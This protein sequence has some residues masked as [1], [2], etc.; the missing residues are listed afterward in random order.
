[1]NK[2]KIRNYP[3]PYKRIRV[4]PDR[5]LRA[6]I[7]ELAMID[8]RI[9]QRLRN[10]K[11]LGNSNVSYPTAEHS[12]FAHSLGVL[13]WATKILNSL[14]DNHNAKHNRQKL[15]ELNNSV[16]NYMKKKLTDVNVAIFGENVFL[17][18]TWFEQL[19]RVYA[20]LHDLSHIPFGHT[21]EDQAALFK[22]HDDDL[23]RLNLVFD[24]LIKEVR[25]SYH[26]KNVD[27]AEELSE[28]AIEYI[29]MVKDIFVVGNITSDP[30]SYDDTRNRWFD[31][32]DEQIYKPLLLSYD[33]VSNT[34][35]ADLMDY[36]LR[37]TLFSSIPKTFDKSL[38]ICMKI[39]EHETTFY[40][41]DKLS[42]KMYR[43]GINISRKKVR[44]DMITAILDLL[45]IRYDLTEKVYY[46]H[47]KI[48]ADS[49]LEKVLRLIKG[50]KNLQFTPK[51]IYEQ[52][53]GDEG[54]ISLLE[55]KIESNGGLSSAK[56]I[57]DEILR[58]NLYKAAFR[59]TRNMPLSKEGRTNVKKCKSPEGRDELE[60][61]IVRELVEDCD[62]DIKAGDIIISYP[63]EKMQEKDAK[64][65]IEWSDGQIFTF[66]RLPL[67]ANYSNEVGVLTE[68]YKTLWSMTVYI[69]PNK[70]QYLRLVEA[71]C[72]TKFDI[73]N[74]SI[75]KNYLTEKYKEIYKSKGD[76]TDIKNKAISIES[77]FI[78]SKAAKGGSQFSNKDRTEIVED[79]YKKAIEVREEK[80][81]SRRENKKTKQQDDNTPSLD[82]DKS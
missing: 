10:T 12:R 28:I 76:M 64:A 39:L 73:N 7:L 68:R 35:C 29:N 52:Y 30:D 27:F 79:S 57:L 9:M 21:I 75:L 4:F 69:N 6:S 31:E 66:E 65:L 37:D 2:T 45:R 63:P 74:E 43:L 48:I 41:P 33:I 78:E 16:R 54:F 34:I 71:V 18:V 17:G 24:M 46:H 23:S 81:K 1:M 55:S 58:R 25:S 61:E 19:V 67:E 3:F 26:F 42:R 15:D 44:H 72:E 77:G 40:K 22:R 59:I 60:K 51:E 20:L 49:M 80:R 13:Y 50:K 11:Q 82:F 36:A 53:L 47:T 70:S 32:I 38:L 56:E 8:T 14:C 5:D 62:A